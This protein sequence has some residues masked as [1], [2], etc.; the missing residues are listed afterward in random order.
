MSEVEGPGTI[1]LS[2][3]EFHAFH[4]VHDYELKRGARFVV[5]LELSV[6][7]PARDTLPDT[8]DYS[9]VFTVVKRIVTGEPFK[10][11]ESLAAAIART[12]MAEEPG[13]HALVVRV[14][15]PHAPLHGIVRDVHYELRRS[16]GED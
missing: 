10:L 12:V 3:M 8:V 7:P 9:R 14:H 1:V 16:R 4:G 5:D 15:K 2:G 11:I 6:T 13:V